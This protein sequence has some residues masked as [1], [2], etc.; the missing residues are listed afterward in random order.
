MR[1]AVV[2]TFA[3]ASLTLIA[4]PTPASADEAPR[5]TWREIW[6]WREVW[7]GVDVSKDNWLVYSG[8]T[9]SPFGH[10]HEPGLRLRAAAGYGQYDYSGDRSLTAKPLIVAF[11]AQTYY[12]EALIG[13]LER[14]GPLTAKAF[15][16]VSTLGHA[17]APLDPEN[18]V[19]GDD[20]GFKGV[21]EL[22]LDIGSVGYASLDM[23][24]NTAH[25]TRSARSRL[26][27]RLSPKM[28]AGI[29]A[30]LDIDAQSECDLG[31]ETRGACAR[32]VSYA[33]EE[34]ELLDDTRAGLFLR[35]EWDGGEISASVGVSGRSFQNSGDGG[36][37]EPYATLNWVK[38]F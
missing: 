20:I 28:S 15:A 4:S 34:T 33:D 7:T 16:G 35:Y 2:A 13:Y 36:N 17:I 30:W 37:P 3:F 1:C 5:P 14:W 22:W 26:G 27:A 19:I 6:K 10:I 8:A 25:D 29:E 12:G 24:W 21:L 32:Q 31:W 9:V 18:A 38:Q 11:S 23:S